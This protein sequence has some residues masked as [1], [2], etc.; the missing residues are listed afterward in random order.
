MDKSVWEEAVREDANKKV[1]GPCDRCK[2]RVYTK[3][4]KGVPIVKRG[5]EEGERVCE[6]AVEEGI[7]PTI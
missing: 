1:M 6:G 5:E 3:E 2:G 7:Y 4:E